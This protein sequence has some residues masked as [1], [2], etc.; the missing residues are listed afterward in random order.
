M[1]SLPAAPSI[2]SE[3]ATPW[4]TLAAKEPVKISSKLPPIMFSMPTNV[5]V[6]IPAASDPFV[7]VAMPVAKLTVIPSVALVYLT[8]S[9]PSPP[10]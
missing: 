6:P 2:R 9:I 4:M 5:S 3:P 7:D 1:V 10:L 8:V